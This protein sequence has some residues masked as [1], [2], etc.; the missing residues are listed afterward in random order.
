MFARSHCKR[1]R[2]QGLLR[3]QYRSGEA[4]DIAMCTCRIGEW[5]RKAGEHVVRTRLNLSAQCQVGWLE[6]FDE[7]KPIKGQVFNGT[8]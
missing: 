2:D 3:I 5:F 8:T 6:D 7:L 1:C 4:Y